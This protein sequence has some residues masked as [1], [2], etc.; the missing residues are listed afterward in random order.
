MTSPLCEACSPAGA[1]VAAGGSLSASLVARAAVAA[2]A[3]LSAIAWPHTT[4]G[5]GWI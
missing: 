2:V 3:V 5:A 4:I 1:V